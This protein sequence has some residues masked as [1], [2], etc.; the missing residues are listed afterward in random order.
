MSTTYNNKVKIK[1]F[2]TAIRLVMERKTDEREEER[3]GS[4]AENHS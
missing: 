2:Q 4:E 3:I 1:L